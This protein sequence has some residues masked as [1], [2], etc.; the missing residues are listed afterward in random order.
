[1][2]IFKLLWFTLG[3]THEISWPTFFTH[4]WSPSVPVRWVD[5][6]NWQAILVTKVSWP[7]PPTSSRRWCCGLNGTAAA[8]SRSWWLAGSFPSEGVAFFC[9]HHIKVCQHYHMKRLIMHHVYM[10]VLTPIPSAE[11]T[12]QKLFFPSK[13]DEMRW[14]SEEPG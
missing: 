6:G 12:W 11:C 5:T 7:W 1:M 13:H 9:P 8:A 4:L 10:K 2:I 3:H 14:E